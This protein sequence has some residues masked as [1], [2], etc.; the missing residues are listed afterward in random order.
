ME[1]LTD[2]FFLINL[3]GQCA[4]RDMD[5]LRFTNKRAVEFANEGCCCLRYCFFVLR[6]YYLQ[7]ISGIL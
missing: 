7:R 6:I 1:L 2:F 5:Y 3:K 4:G